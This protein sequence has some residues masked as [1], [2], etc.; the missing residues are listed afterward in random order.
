MLPGHSNF[1]PFM[2]TFVPLLALAFSVPMP[3]IADSNWSYITDSTEST[4]YFGRNIRQ[5]EGITFVEIKMEDNPGGNNGDKNSWNQAFD[6]KNKTWRQNNDAGF[7][8]IKEGQVNFD[9]FKFAC[10]K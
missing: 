8:P 4:L 9:W 6:C 3:A 1:N 10:K 2:K 5:R 7:V